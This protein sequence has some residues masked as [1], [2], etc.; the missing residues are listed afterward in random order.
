LPRLAK[1]SESLSEQEVNA[2]LNAWDFLEFSNSYRNQY[3]NN[4]YYTPDIVNRKMQDINMNPVDA[5]VEGIEKALKSPKD[6]ETILRN[7]ATSLEVQNMYYKRLIRF[8]SDMPCWN[9]SF[10]VT[11]VSKDSEF[12]SKEFK[13]D[14]A[15]LENFCNKFNFK[16]EFS[17]ALRQMIRQGVFYCILR[18]EGDKYVLQELPPDFCMITGRHSY[19]L[20]FDFDMNWFIGNYGADINMYPRVFKKMYNDV[21][22]RTSN[23]YNPASTVDNRN[24]TFVY[25][26]QCSPSDGF[27][28]FKISPEVATITPYYSALFPEMAMQPIVRGLQEDKYFIEASKLLVGIIGVNKENKSGNNNNQINMT[29]DIL[30]K[31][32]GVA[33]Q[34]LAKQ[35]GLTALPMDDIKAV[36]FDTKERNMLTEYIQN[37]T[38]QSA[39]SSAALLYDEKLNVHQSKLAAAIDENFITS[40]YPMFANFIEYFVNQQTKK[41]KFKITLSDVNT[42]DNRTERQNKFKMLAEKGIVDFQEVAR[43][44]DISPFELGRRLSISKAMGFEDKLTSLASIINPVKTGNQSTNT[45]PSSNGRGRPRKEDSDNESTQDSN[46]RGSN[47]LAKELY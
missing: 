28:A 17:M 24:S 22:R 11:N 30:G 5:T 29:P 37:I 21:F 7:Y 45:I 40:M 36:E 18:D 39:S 20:L 2:V 4:G 1:K 46:A 3:Y 6:N 42:P 47:D 16:E 38:E 8:N 12:K 15:V 32:L 31:F 44:C 23:K 34:G 9:I 10:D 25:W 41:Y 14:L 43:I 27:W 13:E 19:G 33:R 26:H 35:I